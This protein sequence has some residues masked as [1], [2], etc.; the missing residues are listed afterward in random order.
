MPTEP[1][2]C[3]NLVFKEVLRRNPLPWYIRGDGPYH[4]ISSEGDTIARDLNSEQAKAIV[5][6][7]QGQP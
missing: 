4:I 7:A 1:K 3:L 5:M 6:H 2:V